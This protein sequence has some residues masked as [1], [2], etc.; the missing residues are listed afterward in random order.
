M[1]HTTITD[2]EV[3]LLAGTARHK[4]G[5]TIHRHG[6]SGA[7]LPTCNG[8]NE[9]S[10][11]TEGVTVFKHVYSR[12]ILE[13]YLQE[14][15]LTTSELAALANEYIEKRMIAVPVISN[16]DIENF[17]ADIKLMDTGLIGIIRSAVYFHNKKISQSK[18]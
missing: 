7:F 9:E 1:N 14:T 8:V 18:D 4:S 11:F 12:E 10:L 6:N 2:W 15:P 16:E 3:D 5:F 13:Y 17:L